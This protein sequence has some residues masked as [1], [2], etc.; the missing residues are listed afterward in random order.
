MTTWSQPKSLSH[1]VKRFY[2]LRNNLNREI[3]CLF[4]GDRIFIPQNCQEDD[5]R[6]LHSDHIGIV[7]MKMLARSCLLARY[8]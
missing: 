1:S 3:K 8:R 4:Y 6:T 7:R 5:L 2:Q